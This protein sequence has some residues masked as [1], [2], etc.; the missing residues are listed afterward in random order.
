[1]ALGEYSC[2]VSSAASPIG[3]APTMAT[4]SPGLMSPFSTPHS[5][6]GRQDVAEQHN[7]LEIEIRRDP[8]RL[9]SA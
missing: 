5:Y 3:P 1:M 7:R 6:A 2:A 9:V 4:V 8:V